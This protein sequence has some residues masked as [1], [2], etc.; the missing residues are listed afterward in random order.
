LDIATVAGASAGAFVFVVLLVLAVIA[1][2]VFRR[3]RAQ[4]ALA[5]NQ[6]NARA[7]DM[8]SARF[9]DDASSAR[10]GS[11][12]S[13]RESY[14]A[15]PLAQEMAPR[16]SYNAPPLAHDIAPRESYGGSALSQIHKSEGVGDALYD[17]VR[18]VHG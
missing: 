15:P 13:A 11:V 12:A 4:R 7:G 17:D 14:N 2:V 16:E 10:Y 9:D 3:R 1:L 5:R 6:I 18:S 8:S